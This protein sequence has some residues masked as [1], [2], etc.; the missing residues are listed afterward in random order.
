[1]AIRDGLAATK[2]FKGLMISYTADARGDLAHTAG[3][4]QNK[5]KT[6]ELIGSVSEAGF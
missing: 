2:D 1:V 4:Y 3:V 6:P 5:G